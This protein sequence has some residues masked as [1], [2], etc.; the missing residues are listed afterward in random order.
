MCAFG[1]RLDE[2]AEPVDGPWVRRLTEIA[3]QSGVSVAAGMFSPSGEF[4]PNGREKVI[5]NLVITGADQLVV[6]PKIH[7]YDAFGFAESDGVVAGDQPVLVEVGG[8]P[9]GLTICYD[10]RFPG[11]YTTLAERG[12]KLIIVAA[13]WGAGPGKVRQWELLTQARALDSTSFIAAV[14]QADPATIGGEPGGS[15]PT[16]VGHSAVIDPTGAQLVGAGAEPTL[17]ITD[18]DLGQVDQVRTAIPVL[19]NRRF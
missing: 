5:N 10:V 17:L 7:L 16:G 2:V 13:S 4:G 9:I 1:H 15:A 11:L 6:Y 19:D 12:A 8:V 3:T 14:G 18:I